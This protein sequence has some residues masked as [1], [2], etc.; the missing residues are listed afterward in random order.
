MDEKFT[1]TV[2][3]PDIQDTIDLIF[4]VTINRNSRGRSHRRGAM[5]N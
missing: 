3:G 2:T 1:P 5:W 4:L